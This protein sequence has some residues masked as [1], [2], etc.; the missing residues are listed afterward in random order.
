MRR[1]QKCATDKLVA[2]ILELMELREEALTL[3]RALSVLLIRISSNLLALTAQSTSTIP[4][5]R[6][7]RVLLSLPPPQLL[8]SPTPHCPL[9]I[10]PIYY[11]HTP[12]AS[13]RYNSE[14]PK[15]FPFPFGTLEKVQQLSVAC[16][17]N[18]V[19]I[20]ILMAPFSAVDRRGCFISKV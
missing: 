12:F 8:S 6:S 4:F 14:R 7:A 1:R 9:V 19:Q 3:I 16:I 20:G 17:L 13:L 18:V 5:A 11:L 2:H 10:V 15:A